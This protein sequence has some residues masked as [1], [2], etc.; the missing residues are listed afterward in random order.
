MQKYRILR[1]SVRAIIRFVVI[2]L[3]GGTF[4][5][6]Q[7]NGLVWFNMPSQKAYPIKGVDVSAH[8]GQIDWQILA[9]QNLS[10]VFMK[11]TEGSSWV[12]KKF[13]YNFENAH[14]YGLYVGAYHFFSF[15]S[16]GETQAQNFIR[17]VPQTKDGQRFL[18]PVVDIEFYGSNASHPPSVDSVRAELHIL[19]QSLQEHYGL[20]P[21][22]YTTSSFYD[23]YLRGQYEDY[24]LWIR[25]IF[26]S[27]DSVFAKV[28]NMY[29]DKSSW[30][31]WQYNPHGVLDGYHGGE[32]Y[33][34]LNVF[35]GSSQDFERWLKQ[36]RI[37]KE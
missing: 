17:N 37:N 1:W 15:E 11:A 31:F 18:P 30:A 33:I 6:L 22:I 2:I 25:S 19:L 29:F 32:K 23:V 34:D 36:M 24:P 27:P 28:F 20:K 12:D 8:Q 13:A 10:F 9:S 4:F 26:F 7:H 5:V 21:I 35:N 14:K 16:G 3:L